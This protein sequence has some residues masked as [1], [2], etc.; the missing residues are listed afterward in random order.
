MQC[1]QTSQFFFLSSDVFDFSLYSHKFF[2]LIFVEQKFYH[3]RYCPKSFCMISMQFSFSFDPKRKAVN[4]YHSS[5]LLHI[6]E[7]STSISTG[8][9]EKLFMNRCKTLRALD[10]W[11]ETDTKYSISSILGSRW[12][13]RYLR[14]MSAALI[15][16]DTLH[17][18]HSLEILKTVLVSKTYVFPFVYVLLY[19]A[20]SKYH[21]PVT[22]CGLG[23]SLLPWRRRKYLA[24]LPLIVF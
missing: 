16:F 19:C 23:G 9:Y 14:E 21:S 12:K 4:I 5:H 20:W 10:F 7:I 6:Y 2:P 3:K 15:S 24:Y 1:W 8:Q 18:G 13:T 11:A 17:A 22:Y